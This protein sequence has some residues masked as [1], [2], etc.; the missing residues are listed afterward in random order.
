MS[1]WAAEEIMRR[2]GRFCS[3]RSLWQQQQQHSFPGR[4]SIRHESIPTQQV[5]HIWGTKQSHTCLSGSLVTSVRFY[6][7][8]RIHSEDLAEKEPL[9]P[10]PAESPLPT[11]VQT[12]ETALGQSQWKSPFFDHL[13]RCSSPSDVLD[14]TCQY[15]PTVHQVSSCLTHMWSITKKMSDEQQRYELQLMLEHP[16]FDRLLQNAMKN[17]RHMHCEDVA[18]S[19]SAMVQLG[20]PHRSR[21]VQ[22][23]LRHC[24]VGSVRWSAS[25]QTHVGH[26]FVPPFNM[27]CWYFPLLSPYRRNWIRLTR[28]ACPFWPPVW[29]KWRTPRTLQHLRRA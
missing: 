5:A 1:V 11:E 7:Q 23:F 27:L 18:Y 8:D 15:A 14:L 19:L 26:T 10:P 25:R 17:V 16:A 22:T 2:A 6:S 21:V 20:V 24:Q 3:L 9:L 12:D 29:Q 13:W 28:R 4:T